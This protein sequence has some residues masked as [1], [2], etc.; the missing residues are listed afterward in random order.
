MKWELP[1]H[2]PSEWP[3]VRWVTR[4]NA[5]D[6]IATLETQLSEARQDL[7]QTNQ[8]L[9][10]YRINNA[11][12][13]EANAVLTADRDR[14]RVALQGLNAAVDYHWSSTIGVGQRMPDF[15]ANKITDA[16]KLAMQALSTKS[17]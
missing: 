17:A 7:V 8:L 11:Q 4:K 16:Q 14:L 12:Y 5:E 1:W 13:I 3:S 10:P 2:E 15:H 9:E 6:K